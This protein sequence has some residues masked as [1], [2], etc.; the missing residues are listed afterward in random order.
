MEGRILGVPY[1]VNRCRSR[2]SRGLL[3]LAELDLERVWLFPLGARGLLL[4]GAPQRLL[5][6]ADQHQAV[7]ARRRAGL[8]VLPLA[9]RID[10]LPVLPD[11]DHH[12]DAVDALGLALEVIAR[13][14]AH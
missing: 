14:D 1:A 5:R 12:V 6:H 2:R 10:L 7:L 11:V 8:L 9:R 3:A 13:G 4:G